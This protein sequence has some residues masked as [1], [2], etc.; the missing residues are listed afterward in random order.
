[1]I[2]AEIA[3][4]IHE[5]D[6]SQ[7]DRVAGDCLVMSHRWQR[8][9]EAGWRPHRPA[10][11][12]LRDDHGPLAIAST[13]L[14]QSF[15]RQGW[16]GRLLQRLTLTVSAP[17]STAHC[18]VATR[19]DA[20]LATVLPHLKRTLSRLCRRE[21]RLL[22]GVSN[23]ST[24]DLPTWRAHRFLASARPGVSVLRL[25]SDYDRYFAGLSRKGRQELRRARRRGAKFHVSFEHGPLT[26]Q[27]ERWYPLLREVFVRHGT[28]AD[29]MPFTAEFLAILARELPGQVVAFRGFVDGKA[30]GLLLGLVGRRTLWV[31]LAGLRYELARPSYLYFVL[32][33]EMVSWSIQHGLK[34]IYG[35]IGNA[36]Q[37]KRH[38]F[39]IRKRW[40]CYQLYPSLLHQAW[41]AV[42]LFL[43]R[44]K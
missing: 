31:P 27:D 20:S 18:G 17:L 4:A 13:N 29:E 1:M 38:G 9:L 12:L 28:L 43:K 32:T 23:V 10:Y 6:E 35:G 22:L 11:V 19:P 44:T 5:L 15:G 8:V 24:T 3:Q 30:A 25:P 37:K 7:W 2:T 34:R 21:K 36:R 40:F 14:S 41:T 26:K 33:D 16:L 42:Q 39:H